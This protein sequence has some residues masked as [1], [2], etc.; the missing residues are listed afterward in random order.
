MSVCLC[1][2]L[3]TTGCNKFIK[4]KAVYSAAIHHTVHAV[5]STSFSCN[6]CTHG[7]QSG[8]HK[9]TE[10]PRAFLLVALSFVVCVLS[11]FSAV[12]EVKADKSNAV[13]CA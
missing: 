11:R 9:N 2:S 7:Q 1:A 12:G 13:T 10:R 3:F 6:I 5:G 4:V 8:T